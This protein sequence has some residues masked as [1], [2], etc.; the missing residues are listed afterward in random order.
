[1]PTAEQSSEQERRR[2]IAAESAAGICFA[3]DVASAG[4]TI[5]LVRL[6]ARIVESCSR[7]GQACWKLTTSPSALAHAQLVTTIAGEQQ[8]ASEGIREKISSMHFTTSTEKTEGHRVAS[9]SNAGHLTAGQLFRNS[10]RGTTQWRLPDLRQTRLNGLVPAA[11]SGADYLLIY[12]LYWWGAFARG[13]LFEQVV[14]RD[15]DAAGVQFPGSRAGTGSG[16]LYA[17][18]SFCASTGSRRHQGISLFLDDL[19]DPPADFY[20]T[21]LYDVEQRAVRQVVF[22]TPHAWRRIDSTPRPASIVE[23][24]RLFPSPVLVEIGGTPWVVV[25]YGVWKDHVLRWQLEGGSHD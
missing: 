10:D 14:I 13:Y 21:R 23:A 6:S 8:D 18:R 5:R 20:I 22:L 11:V 1:V 19:P 15:M 17:V 2:S 24:P 4:I 3:R 25:E 9:T 7:D 12:C 16:A